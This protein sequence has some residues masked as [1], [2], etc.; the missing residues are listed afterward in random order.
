MIIIASRAI[1]DHV[2]NRH[3][4]TILAGIGA[5]HMAAWCNL[6]IGT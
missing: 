6:L 5:A 4:S 3:Y 1:V 2:V